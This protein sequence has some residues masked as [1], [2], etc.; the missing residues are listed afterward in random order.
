MA[1]GA[2]QPETAAAL[3]EANLPPDRAA[4]LIALARG[5]CAIGRL[6]DGGDGGQFSVFNFI[7]RAA[8]EPAPAPAHRR[9]LV[10]LLRAGVFRRHA[11]FMRVY[12]ADDSHP[13]RLEL[14]APL[15]GDWD[16]W[17]DLQEIRKRLVTE[18]IWAEAVGRS[19]AE[20]VQQARE[21]LVNAELIKLDRR[22]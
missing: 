16:W 2:I 17:A 9:S 4:E 20:A 13:M 8:Y 18:P 1:A 11:W 21:E 7:I 6:R 22:A 15:D 19:Y 12:A 10:V 14:P 5:L 3:A